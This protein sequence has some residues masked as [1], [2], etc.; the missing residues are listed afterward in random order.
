MKKRFVIWA[1]I[2]I[3]LGCVWHFFYPWFPHPLTGFFAPVDESIWE[4]LK[5][6]YW[7]MLPAILFLGKQFGFRTTGSAFLVQL[8]WMPVFLVALYY[9]LYAG[10]GIDSGVI[11][12]ALY[13]V[14][15]TLGFIR[16]Y[17]LTGS[18]KA[19]RYCG[20]LLM[21]TALYGCALILFTVAS[22]DL[23]IFQP[24]QDFPCKISEKS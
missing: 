16:A 4:H 9:A 5:L 22:P 1:G 19:A 15:V 21:L 14:T 12:I 2:T 24:S 6:L 20:E 7:P 18:G 23:P 3:I 13:V 17:R 10:F 11:N 8:L